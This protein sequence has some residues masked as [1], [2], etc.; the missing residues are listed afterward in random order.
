MRAAILHTIGEEKLD[1]RDDVEVLGP[2]LGEVHL[3][4]RA[5]GVCHSDLSAIQW[6]AA[7]GARGPRPRGGR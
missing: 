7:A 1:L 2:D 5:S 3:R 6:P 4:V